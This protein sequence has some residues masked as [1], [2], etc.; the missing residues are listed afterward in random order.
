MKTDSGDNI[1]FYSDDELKVWLKAFD[2]IDPDKITAPNIPFS[3]PEI[4]RELLK[5][6]SIRD[7]E[8]SAL[9]GHAWLVGG[10]RSD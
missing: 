9:V 10:K 5:R 6:E 7:I 1:A 8:S 3:Y 4:R 2:A